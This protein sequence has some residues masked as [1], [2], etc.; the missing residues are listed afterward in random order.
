MRRT[1]V[2]GLVALLALGASGC[3]IGRGSSGRRTA[4]IGNGLLMATG[5]RGGGVQP[6]TLEDAP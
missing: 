1:A 2:V 4:Y 5:G 6:Q 3:F